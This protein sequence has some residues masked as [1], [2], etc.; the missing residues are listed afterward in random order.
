MNNNSI[1]HLDLKASG[2][3]FL[4]RLRGLQ[5]ISDFFSTFGD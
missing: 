4:F 5:G 1:F 3:L 2:S